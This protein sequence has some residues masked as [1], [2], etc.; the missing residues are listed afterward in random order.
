MNDCLQGNLSLVTSAATKED[1]F[2][3][4]ARAGTDLAGWGQMIISPRGGSG[5]TPAPFFESAN[6]YYGTKS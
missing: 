5:Y 3:R 1:V 4:T 6:K 2:E